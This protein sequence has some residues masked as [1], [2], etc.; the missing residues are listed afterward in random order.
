MHVMIIEDETSIIDVLEAYLKREGHTVTS[1]TNGR[2]GLERFHEEQPDFLIL[3]LMLPDLSGEAICTDI[4]RTST[5]PIL[6]LSAKAAEAERIQGMM[7]GA[8]DYVVKPFSP[9]EI[10]VRMD[11]VMR[12]V[13][14][15]S[16]R[17][18]VW[19]FQ[20]GELVIKPKERLVYK[21]GGQL[22]LTPIEY[23]LLEA[24]AAHPGWV[25]ER[26][27]LLE[28][29]QQDG[30]YE[31]YERSIDVHIKNLRRKIEEEPSEPKWIQTVFGMGYKF[32]GERDA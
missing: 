29:V 17:E 22:H 3:D 4:R 31:G 9:R 5:T 15:P 30:F 12:R 21:R 8:D 2:R 16:E 13:K 7:L 25:Y 26:A 6:M 11:A 10:M 19:S 20:Q 1:E 32:Q 27:D 23:R 18:E 24:M 14:P 28:K